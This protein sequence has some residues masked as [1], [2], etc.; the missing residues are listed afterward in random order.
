MAET[1]PREQT[2]SGTSTG[3]SSIHSH[4]T[5]QQMQRTQEDTWRME[6]IEDYPHPQEGRPGYSQQPD[7][8]IGQTICLLRCSQAPDSDTARKPTRLRTEGL[9]PD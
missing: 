7:E 2:E 3:K 1:L 4:R 6:K 8:Y 5:L 9:P